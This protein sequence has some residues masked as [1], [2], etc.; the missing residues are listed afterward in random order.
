M[1]S[2]WLR[3]VRFLG[4]AEVRDVAIVDGLIAETAPTG[5]Q[6][7]D[8]EGRFVMPGLWD[9]HAHMSQWSITARRLFIGDAGSA[10]EVARRC[11]AAIVED[12]PLIAFGFH[13]AA[14][15][16]RPTTTLLD[17]VCGEHPVV[18]VGGDLHCCWAN[19]AGLRRY[20]MEHSDDLL[21]EE[22][23]FELQRRISAVPETT[24]DQWVLEAA[25]DAARKGVVG[26]VDMEMSWN[27]DV[28]QRRMTAGFDIF[29]VRASVYPQHLDQALAAGLRSGDV[30]PRFPLLEVGPF[31]IITDGSLN[32]RTAYC[33]DPYPGSDNRGVM[34]FGYEA[35]CDY[36]TRATNGGFWCTAHAIGDAANT[37]V[38]DAFEATGAPG[39]VEHAQLL[40]DAD[41][42]R[43]KHLGIQASIQPQH[44]LDDRDVA[45]LI[46]AGRTARTYRFADLHAAGAELVFGSDAPVA[47]LDPW[48]AIQAG[49]ERALPGDEP[50]HPEQRLPIETCLAASTDGRGI[51]P[52]V[53]APAD[54]I[55]CDVDPTLASG[56]VLR[57][58]P[59]AATLLRGRFTHSWL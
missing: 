48:E 40:S 47:P 3:N 26:I 36:F 24:L 4:C 35:I 21:R 54:L 46:W 45:D 7:I 9:Q 28:W 43:F 30:D 31:K 33:V 8:C 18:I 17:D 57:E 10:A 29:G 41:L 2:L 32:T 55:L 49:V 5:S 42:A 19:S 12:E 50:W 52:Q 59:V 39:R 16:D 13:D 53:G 1:T 58:L 14:W 27:Q 11:A 22:P 23:A 38:L 44:L 6:E 56:Q 25:Q 34:T 15:P 51:T 37:L 20:G